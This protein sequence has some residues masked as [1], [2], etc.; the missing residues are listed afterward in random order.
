MNKKFSNISEVS[1][2]VCIVG[3]CIYLA[4]FIFLPAVSQNYLE[5][6]RL[7]NESVEVTAEITKIDEDQ[8]SD[9]DS[10]YDI[11][12]TYTYE[13]EKYS[14]VYYDRVGA[15]PEYGE[16][17]MVQIDPQ[18]PSNVRETTSSVNWKIYGF[19]LMCIAG[20]WIF[21]SQLYEMIMAKKTEDIWQEFYHTKYLQCDIIKQELIKTGKSEKKCNAL[22]SAVLFALA[23]FG[24]IFGTCIYGNSTF[25]IFLAV[26]HGIVM[27]IYI[28]KMAIICYPKESEEIHL[29]KNTIHKVEIDN[30]GSDLKKIIFSG[31]Y[32]WDAKERVLV[33]FS[34][35]HW[36]YVDKKR[37]DIPVYIALNENKQ[38]QR[39]FNAKKYE[40]QSD[41]LNP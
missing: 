34:E 35:I 11:F 13:G 27:L 31:G 5:Y 2:F 36:Y 15:E 22:F 39:I 10:D 12:V 8:D 33:D 3:L 32:A 19:P 25:G 20:L 18:N 14:N 28:M 41:S 17:I 37:L 6:V 16:K 40:F 9:G 38:I 29:I 23:I 24:S 21:S 1:V 4:F 7:G 30:D 26:P